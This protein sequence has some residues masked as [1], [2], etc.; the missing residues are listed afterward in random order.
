MTT[1]ERDQQFL[2]RRRG[3]IALIGAGTAALMA[4]FGAFG[5]ML[6]GRPGTGVLVTIA[7]LTGAFAAL[8]AA[9]VLPLSR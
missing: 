4:A 3:C 8:L 9:M 5:P 1:G 7:V 6:D 2:R